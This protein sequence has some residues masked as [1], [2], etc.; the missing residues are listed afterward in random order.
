[1][2]D[3]VDDDFSEKGG[4]SGD[5][6]VIKAMDILFAR[7]V[8]YPMGTVQFVVGEANQH[9]EV[10]YIKALL[11]KRE[12]TDYEVAVSDIDSNVY[13]VSAQ[14]MIEMINRNWYVEIENVDKS[15]TP[16]TKRRILCPL[17]VPKMYEAEELVKNHSKNDRLR[18]FF[19]KFPFYPMQ[20]DLPNL[21]IPSEEYDYD[22]WS[23]ELPTQEN[24]RNFVGAPTNI[25]YNGAMYAANCRHEVHL[26]WEHPWCAECLSLADILVCGMEADDASSEES[27]RCEIC[28]R[29]TPEAIQEFTETC[30]DVGTTMDAEGDDYEYSDKRLHKSIRCQIDADLATLPHFRTGP[31]PAWAKGKMGYCRPATLWPMF[32]TTD[33]YAKTSAKEM[34]ANVDQQLV[35]FK[36]KYLECCD[37]YGTDDKVWIALETCEHVN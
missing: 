33:M 9:K 31:N 35:N 10:D 11:T 8:K 14:V 15:T 23:I 29:L 37:F 19:D 6:L 16:H 24:W 26:W 18:H 32:F 3:R 28:E 20:H 4:D 1:M 22:E 7:E 5:K 34:E 27:D 17:S 2:S 36:T 30:I 13:H 25:L 12:N 21:C